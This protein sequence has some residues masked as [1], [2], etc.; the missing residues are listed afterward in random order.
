MLINF[1]GSAYWILHLIVIFIYTCP[2]LNA[3][4]LNE[5]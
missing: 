4:L 5:I 1:E 3:D 2:D